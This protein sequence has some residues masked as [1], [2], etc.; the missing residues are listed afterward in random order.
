LPHP[1]RAAH[2]PNAPF[3]PRLRK[4]RTDNANWCCIRITS[5]CCNRYRLQAPMRPRGDRPRS[6]KRHMNQFVAFS[7]RRNDAF[8]GRPLGQPR[9]GAIERQGRGR[10]R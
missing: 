5:N 8:L 1:G 2:L 6:H 7:F 10:P 4:S 3:H 9:T